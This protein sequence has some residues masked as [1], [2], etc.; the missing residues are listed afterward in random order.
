MVALLFIGGLFFLVVVPILAIVAASRAGALRTDVTRLQSAVDTL[1]R[2]IAEL[3]KVRPPEATA[4]ALPPFA[5]VAKTEQ[6]I[7]R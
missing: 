1:H 2:R 6:T 4:P 7:A 5:G 3:E